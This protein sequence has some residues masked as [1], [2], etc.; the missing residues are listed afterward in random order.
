MLGT[1]QVGGSVRPLKFSLCLRNFAFPAD[2]KLSYLN[3]IEACGLWQKRR[4]EESFPWHSQVVKAKGT[5][6]R[7]TKN[8]SVD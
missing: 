3:D 8:V 2:I 7:G 5:I 1:F 4:E 6:L